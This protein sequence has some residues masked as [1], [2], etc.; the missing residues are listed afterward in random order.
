MTLVDKR[1]V[2]RLDRNSWVVC[3]GDRVTDQTTA[4]VEQRAFLEGWVEVWLA[5]EHGVQALDGGDTD[6]SQR[7]ESVGAEQLDVVKLGELP[8]I[9]G[10]DVLLELLERLADQ[11]CTINK[12]QHALRATKLYQPIDR[13][14]VLTMR[15]GPLRCSGMAHL[16]GP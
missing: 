9:V 7:I 2:E 5:L 4:G 12:E 13:G 16:S 1:E 3:H 11:V 6:A 15:N 10:S 14:V 8:T